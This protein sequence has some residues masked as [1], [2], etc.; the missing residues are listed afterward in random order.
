MPIRRLSTTTL[1]ALALTLIS[2]LALAACGGASSSKSTSPS[3]KAAN[4]NTATQGFKAASTSASS[5]PAPS[6]EPA[7]S[8]LVA[9]VQ[10]FPA[11]RFSEVKHLMTI[12]SA[13]APVPVPPSYSACIAKSRERIEG[14]G[15][16]KVPVEAE[17]KSECQKRYETLLGNS[18]S[19]AIHNQWLLG[20]AREEKIQISPEAVLREF[21]AS[22]KSYKS[23]A[24]FESY[25]QSS[26]ESIDDMLAEVKI[27]QIADRIFA[28][29]KAK[30]RL[31]TSAVV[32][33]FYDS[34]RSQ[35]AIPAGRDVRIVRTTT[36]AG[37]ESAIRQLR[38]GESFAQVAKGLS[39]IGQP[40]NTRHGEVK[41]L[42]PG[43]FEEKPLN[44]AV[45][46]AKLHV[47]SGPLELIAKHKTIAPETNTGFFVYEV[48]AITP[49]G[50]TPL[51]KVKAQIAAKLFE[52]D[53]NST[54]GGYIAAFRSRWTARTD[55]K[56]GYVVR[57]CKQF[58]GA[59]A[60]EAVDPYTL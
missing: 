31:I 48:T 39:Q 5:T 19:G 46:S 9:Q 38:A 28:R 47:L 55:C 58:K 1:L 3:A 12:A 45:F 23:N 4:H 18:V 7:P 54:L 13:P 52:A 35:F 34:H 51:S 10:G 22:K 24:E 32:A 29:I 27:N 41:G 42:L 57:N 17:L 21:D 59:K 60:A 43:V 15:E 40:A 36:K 11:I 49:P 50:Q 26:G 14:A 37:A 2:A 6:S 44:D 25:R 16:G 56:A 20:Q 33:S 30:R 8:T 53:K